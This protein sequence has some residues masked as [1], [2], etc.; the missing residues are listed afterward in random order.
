MSRNCHWQIG[1]R[2]LLCD[3]YWIS[4]WIQLAQSVFCAKELQV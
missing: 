3:F 4:Y 2:L 1:G